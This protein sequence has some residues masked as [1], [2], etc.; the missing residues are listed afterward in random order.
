MF[1]AAKSAAS[2]GQPA[3]RPFPCVFQS[4]RRLYCCLHAAPAEIESIYWLDSPNANKAQRT[5]RCSNCAPVWFATFIWNRENVRRQG[6]HRATRRTGR[7]RAGIECSEVMGRRIGCYASLIGRDTVLPAVDLGFSG[8]L[9]LSGVDSE[10]IRG[11]LETL[12]RDAAA[13][14][15]GF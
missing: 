5:L 13:V 15:E 9:G 7:Q 12:A 8:R 14:S 11:K 3:G 6:V 10:L 2:R 4:A 1:R